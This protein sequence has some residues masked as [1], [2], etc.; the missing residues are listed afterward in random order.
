MNN[1]LFDAI[2]TFADKLGSLFFNE[3]GGN[4]ID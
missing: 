4:N 1:R 3:I 2:T